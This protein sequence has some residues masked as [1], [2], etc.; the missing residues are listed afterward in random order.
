M[1]YLTADSGIV[2]G[3]HFRTARAAFIYEGPVRRALQ[4]LKYGGVARVAEPLADAALPTLRELLGEAGPA[5]LVPIPV[6]PARQR[7]RG[8]NQAELLARRLA[9]GTRRPVADALVRRRHTAKQHTLDRAGRLRNLASAF[10]LRREGGHPP[11]RV[12]VMI[13]DIMTTSATLET[14]AAVLLAGGVEEVYGLA[15]AREV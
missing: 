11:A 3:T 10:A 12:V 4:R 7:E 1:R 9:R 13:D 14:C 15:I 6:H 2:I 5:L 8:Y